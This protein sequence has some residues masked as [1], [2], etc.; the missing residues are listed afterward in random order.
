MI[1]SVLASLTGGRSDR[2]VL[3]AAVAVG[4]ID[5]AAIQCLHT[6]ADIA[7]T[8]AWF[9]ATTVRSDNFREFAQ[10]LLQ[11][12]NDMSQ[13]AHSAFRD[14]CERHALSMDGSATKP[15][16]ISVS[17]EEVTTSQDETLRRARFHDLAVVGRDE[18]YSAEQNHNLLMQSGR[19]ILIAPAKPVTAIGRVVAIAWKEG[20]DAARAITAASPILSRAE[21]IVILSVTED[22]VAR[23]SER[24]SADHIAMH[25]GR[26]G[27]P[28]LV[29]QDISPSVST[30]KAIQDMAYG[31]DADLLVM[32]AYGHSRMREF[33]L[34]GVTED[35]L[36][37]CAIPVFMFR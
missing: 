25:V 1:K 29:Q 9:G 10:K 19:P 6:R 34:G 16:G 24:A 26:Y 33:V 7:E 21:R 31:C 23:E 13:Q 5:G 18:R 32:G 20:P 35:M 14:A 11:D 28:T 2:S 8:A 37:D 4:K 22:Q 27:V 15:A 36:E 17:W 3:D 12:E 30:T